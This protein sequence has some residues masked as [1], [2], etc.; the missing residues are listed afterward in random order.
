MFTR[1]GFLNVC[2]LVAIAL[3]GAAAMPRP[4]SP[5]L[6]RAGSARV[7]PAPTCRSPESASVA[8]GHADAQGPQADELSNAPNPFM[9]YRMTVT[10]AH[11]SGSPTY[12]VPGYF[13]GDGD[14]ANSSATPATS[15]A[16]I[17]RPTRPDDGPIG[18]RS[19]RA[20]AVA[21]AAAQPASRLRRSTAGRGRSRS[22]RPTRHAPD[23]RARGR[24]Q[25]AASTIC[26]LPAAANTS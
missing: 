18:S 13:A 26:S 9:D 10:F 7:D 20:K 5:R 1:R 2:A 19:C 17:W 16:R 24:L 12:I 15:G 21:L 6:R 25:Y 8:Q 14:A 4:P 22:L 23:F 11:E 3:A